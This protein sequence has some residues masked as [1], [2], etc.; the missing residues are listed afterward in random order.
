[1][2]L[3]DNVAESHTAVSLENFA[4]DSAHASSDI[5]PTQ[6]ARNIQKNNRPKKGKS[7]PQDTVPFSSGKDHLN[8]NSVHFCRTTQFSDNGSETSVHLPHW[9]SCSLSSVILRG[10]QTLAFDKPTQ[11]QKLAIPAILDGDDVIGQAST[12]S[13]K[14]LAFGLPILQHILTSTDR[15]KE[16]TALIVAPTRELAQ[17][18]SQHLKA[19]GKSMDANIVSITGGMSLDKQ[20]RLL[21]YVPDIV[22]AT[23]GRLWDIISTREE[24]ADLFRRLRF[25]VLDEAD[26]LLQTGHFKEVQDILEALGSPEERQTLIFSATFDRDLQLKLSKGDLK[27]NSEKSTVQE[28][29][30]LLLHKLDFRKP[31]RF[32]NANSNTTVAEAVRQCVIE[33]D[34]VEKDYYLYYILLRYSARTLVFT[35]SIGDVHRLVRLLNALDIPALGLHSNKQQ[36][37]RLTTIE[38]FKAEPNR[39]LVATD[40]AARG[41][42]IASVD[43]VIHFHLPTT[44]DLYIHRSGRTARGHKS[45]LSIAI[46]SSTEIPKLKKMQRALGISNLPEFPIDTA[47]VGAVKP[48]VNLARSICKLETELANTSGRSDNWLAEAAADLGA[49]LSDA[50]EEDQAAQKTKVQLQ[51]LKLRIKDEMKTPI[52][53]GISTRYLTKNGS[54]VVDRLISSQSHKHFLGQKVQT[55][56]ASLD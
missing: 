26:R 13:G 11:I 44:T 51:K 27:S 29:L 23:P 39:I 4:T 35:N 38:R 43:T 54:Q 48:R 34:P 12:G 22:V 3:G 32:I 53:S 15:Q 55:A 5:L 10:L 30:E 21:N 6:P 19:V 28:S 1:M 41:L 16:I 25:L 46:C 56:L 47:N 17:Q 31:P 9:E 36:K 2:D 45:G 40:I 49:D 33:T 7:V 42:D 37:A 18:I 8:D 20:L 24:P 14:T 52:T 50:G